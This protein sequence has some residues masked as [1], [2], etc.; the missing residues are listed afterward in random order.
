VYTRTR[1]HTYYYTGLAMIAL[2]RLATRDMWSETM[3][4]YE[5]RRQAGSFRAAGVEAAKAALFNH[6]IAQNMMQRENALKAAREALP[7]CQ[8]GEEIQALKDAQLLTCDMDPCVETCGT[9]LALLY[10]PLFVSLSSSILFNLITAVLMRELVHSGTAGATLIT[11]NLSV[12]QLDRTTRIWRLNARIKRRARSRLLKKLTALVVADAISLEEFE[13]I[14]ADLIE[15][16][17]GAPTP[18]QL[19]HIDL[20]IWYAETRQKLQKDSE[21]QGFAKDIAGPASHRHASN[22]RIP[23]IKEWNETAS[24]NKKQR[25]QEISAIVN[26]VLD[27]RASKVGSSRTAGNKR[28]GK[29]QRKLK[30]DIC[31]VFVCV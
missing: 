11:P 15:A 3:S 22:A 30:Q 31:Q 19:K 4:I 25:T 13:T 26:L 23:S 29:F 17:L 6:T 12:V 9:A 1:T 18:L 28:R 2:F 20:S 14:V 5:L 24:T 10:F 7:V 21:R 8:T 16:F 27:V